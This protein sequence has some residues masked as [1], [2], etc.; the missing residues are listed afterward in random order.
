TYP[1]ESDSSRRPASA[2]SDL[3]SEAI[4]GHREANRELLGGDRDSDGGARP[5]FLE[6]RDGRDLQVTRVRTTRA[7]RYR[8]R[9]SYPCLRLTC[10][11]CQFEAQWSES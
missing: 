7:E 9:S 10:G 4:L 2:T 11:I 6:P 3:D 1:P 5:T 8:G